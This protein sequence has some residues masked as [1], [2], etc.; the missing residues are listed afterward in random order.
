MKWFIPFH[1]NTAA[2]EQGL[3]WKTGAKNRQL[4][5]NWERKQF[6]I[7]I[8]FD[9][10]ESMVIASMGRKLISWIGFNIPSSNGHTYMLKWGTVASSVGLHRVISC[11]NVHFHVNFA[12]YTTQNEHGNIHA[13]Y[14]WPPLRSATTWGFEKLMTCTRMAQ[15]K[16]FSLGWL[17]DRPQRLQAFHVHFTFYLIVL[18]LNM[19]W[20]WDRLASS[21]HQEVEP[22]W[23]QW[24]RLVFTVKHL[25]SLHVSVLFSCFKLLLYHKIRK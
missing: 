2:D 7:W 25:P 5:A 16:Q 14:I 1:H 21:A 20:T 10:V 15:V 12:F 17:T 23:D 6:C 19:K 18:R 22:P 3:I 9:H 8:Y 13:T 4:A 11:D 24:G